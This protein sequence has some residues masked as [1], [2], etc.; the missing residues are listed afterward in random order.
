MRALDGHALL[1]NEVEFRRANESAG[2]LIT[3]DA[4]TL[5]FAVR[6]TGIGIPLDKQSRLFE[7]VHAGRHVDDAPVRRHRVGADHHQTSG[8]AYGWARLVRERAGPGQYLLFH[9]VLW[10]PGRSGR[11]D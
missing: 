1:K 3:A 9:G 7:T 8:R 6:D 4:V 2:R 5:V 11:R 10:T